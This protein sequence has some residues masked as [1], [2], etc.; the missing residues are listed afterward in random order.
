MFNNIFVHYFSD[1]RKYIRSRK[2]KF[3]WRNYKTRI[4][5]GNA[6]V[7]KYTTS[8]KEA[9]VGDKCHASTGGEQ[10]T[11]ESTPDWKLQSTEK[12]KWSTEG[13]EPSTEDWEQSTEEPDSWKSSVRISSQRRK[14]SSRISPSERETTSPIWSGASN[15]GTGSYQYRVYQQKINSKYDIF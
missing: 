11:N 7:R 10:S 4:W 9:S 1:F 6:G 13:W 2:E 12:W 8:W 14:A 15:K 3:D 5:Q